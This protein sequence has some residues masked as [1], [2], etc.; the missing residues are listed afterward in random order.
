MPCR[1]KGYGEMSKTRLDVLLTEKG[2]APSREKARA[3]IMSGVV[4]VGGQRVDKPG[5][6]VPDD[7]EIEIHGQTQQYVSRG[8]LKLEK[9]IREFSVDPAGKTCI[10]CGASTGGFTDVL[11]K[12]GASKVY[13][14]DVGYGQLAWSIRSDERVVVM[15][16]TNIRNVTREQIPDAPQLAAIDV[17]FISLSKVLPVLKELLSPEGEVVCLIKPQFEAGRGKVG[18]KGVVRELS[19]HIEVLENF[20]KNAAE[21]GFGVLDITFS[22]IKGPEGNIEYLGHLISGAESRAID[23]AEIAEKSHGELK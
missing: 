22:P 8:G 19:T 23:V 7:G 6:Q 10:D 13:A 12:N 17:S 16:R 2:L 9:A 11:L 15:E 20:L 4:F 1:R 3:M 14:I 5:T 18:K 21:A